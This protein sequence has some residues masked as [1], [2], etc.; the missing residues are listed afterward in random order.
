[1]EATF[2]KYEL[3]GGSLSF[4]ETQLIQEVEAA[5]IEDLKEYVVKTFPGE[6]LWVVNKSRRDTKPFMVVPMKLG[7]PIAPTPRR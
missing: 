1:M 2:D 6:T 7:P 5:S 4:P 3:R